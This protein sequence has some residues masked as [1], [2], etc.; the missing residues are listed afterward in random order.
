MPTVKPSFCFDSTLMPYFFKAIVHG[1]GN[2]DHHA[3][4]NVAFGTIAIQHDIYSCNQQNGDT[5][6]Q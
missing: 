4:N 3:C 2:N 1:R 5:N 6:G